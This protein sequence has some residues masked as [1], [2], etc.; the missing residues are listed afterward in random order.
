MSDTEAKTKK[1]SARKLRKLRQD[2]MVASSAETAGYLAVASGLGIFLALFGSMIRSIYEMFE[3]TQTAM[4]L[5]FGDAVRAVSADI[6]WRLFKIVAP[7]AGAAVC[8]AIVVSILFNGGLPISTKPLAPQI[9]RISPVSGLKRIYGRRGWIETA[10]AFVRMSVWLVFVALV[11]LI[12]LPRFAGAVQCGFACQIQTAL[13]GL[14]LM[15]IGLIIVLLLS[16]GAEM[17]VQKS[18]F[19]FEQMMT[20]SETKQERKESFG[21]PGIR[22][23]RR[24][25]MREDPPDQNAV[26]VE[27]AN[28][29]FYSKGQAVAIRY[30]PQQASTPRVSAR[31]EGRAVAQFQD[32]LR[33]G[34]LPVVESD[35]LVKGCWG[36]E[37]GG[38]MPSDLY[39]IFANTLRAAMT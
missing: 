22:A 19:L 23:E 31:L 33:G 21:D 36:I 27:K 28:I 18:L 29:C 9:D 24:R 5:P 32:R 7:V 17:M 1:A 34:G 11:A 37:P 12:W 35:R 13:P 16:A 14:W 3:V 26:G 30:H 20:E 4:A 15:A 10:T 8:V 2:G 39:E 25:R 6:A 38:A